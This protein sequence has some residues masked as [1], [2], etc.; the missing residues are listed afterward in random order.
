MEKPLIG[1]V[2]L[3]DEDKDSYW[4]MPG[5]MK[6][7]EAAGGVPV[8][9]PLT[10]DAETVD[11]LANALDGFVFTGGHDIDPARYGE[12]KADVCGALCPERDRMEAILF[13]RALE[14][15]KP[16]FGICRGLQ[17]FNVLLGGT[18]YQD[19]PSQ[20]QAD[21]AVSHKQEH[22]Y[23]EPAHAVRIEK[24]TLLHRLLRTDEIRVNTL[25]H[26]GIKRLAE[27][28]VAAARAEDG[29]VESVVLPSKRF[30]LAVQW[31]PEFNFETDANSRKLFDAF[32]DACRR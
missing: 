31:H 5:Y 26:Q 23:A 12:A 15:D 11:R 14:L 8:M 3:Y 20:L 1:I 13:E 9:L 32:V 18:L 29:L 19:L 27:P 6:G 22:P 2:P 16:A 25:H 7:I 30:A 28:L 4:M 17:L 21:V 10:G 24:E